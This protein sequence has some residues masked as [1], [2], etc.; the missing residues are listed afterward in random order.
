MQNT[1]SPS[2]ISLNYLFELFLINYCIY[3]AFGNYLKCQFF[4]QFILILSLS[5]T[6]VF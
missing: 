2:C 5:N 6:N 3:L 4:F 1:C